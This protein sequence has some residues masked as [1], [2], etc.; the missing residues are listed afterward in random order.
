MCL[1]TFFYLYN[2]IAVYFLEGAEK[3]S[4]CVIKGECFFSYLNYRQY[5]LPSGTVM[6]GSITLLRQNIFCGELL[7]FHTFGVC[8][9]GMIF[10]FVLCSVGVFVLNQNHVPNL[11]KESE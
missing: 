2:L 11:H 1:H 8:S 9:S 10:V 4:S 7:L 3:F 6:D 5:V